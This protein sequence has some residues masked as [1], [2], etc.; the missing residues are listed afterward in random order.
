MQQ[1]TPCPQESDSGTLRE[2]LLFLF[3]SLLSLLFSLRVVLLQ[4]KNGDSAETAAESASLRAA[5]AVLALGVTGFFLTLLLAQRRALPPD[6]A[7]RTRSAADQAVLSALLAFLSA[8]FRLSALSL[9][10]L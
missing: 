8:L 1:C 6:A 5:G 2:I 7:G 3:L 10:D 4:E 9:T